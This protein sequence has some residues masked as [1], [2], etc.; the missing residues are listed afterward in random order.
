MFG[1][2]HITLYLPTPGDREVL[3]YIESG[4]PLTELDISL[5]ELFGHNISVG[6]DNLKMWQQLE[7]ANL[8]LERRVAERTLG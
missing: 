5:L 4:R 6:Y 2:E 8:L 3:V 1:A 7:E